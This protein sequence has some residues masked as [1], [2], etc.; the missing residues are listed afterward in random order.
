[1]NR[2]WDIL[3]ANRGAERFFGFLLGDR[4]GEPANVVRLMFSPAG[5]RPFVVNWEAVAEALLRRIQRESVGG[6]RDDATLKLVDEVLGYPGV[7]SRW[8][9]PSLLAA[10]TP[11]IPVSFRK[12]GKSFDYFSTVTTLG[13]PQ[14]I[15]LQEIRIE[16]FF[17]VDEGTERGAR[18]LESG[19]RY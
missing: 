4:A 14:D 11:I 9:E 6:V 17:P 7:P 10:L 2:R 3:R 8:R 18:E 12:D 5:L 13:T 1:M 16:C 15:T 19:G